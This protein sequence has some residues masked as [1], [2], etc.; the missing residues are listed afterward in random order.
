M[1]FIGKGRGITQGEEDEYNH[2]S[3]NMCMNMSKTKKKNVFLSE[4]GISGVDKSDL[5]RAYIFILL[6]RD[7]CYP[8]I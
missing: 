2:S 7:V 8:L 4:Y 1:G 3:F 6:H 5:D